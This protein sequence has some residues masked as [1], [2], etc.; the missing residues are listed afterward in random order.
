[1]EQIPT[2]KPSDPQPV[3]PNSEQR[4][5]GFWWNSLSDGVKAA[6]IAGV[7]GLC[8]ACI[9][10]AGALGAPIV[11]AWLSRPTATFTPPST[12]AP[13][14]TRPPT[15]TSVPPTPTKAIAP[16]PTST[17]YAAVE[18]FTILK[19]GIVIDLVR[20]DETTNVGVGWSVTVRAEIFASANL[21]DLKFTWWT[22]QTGDQI[23]VWG[24]GILEMPYAAPTV[25][26]HDCIRVKIEKG[27]E[28]LNN[29][30][31][32]VNIQ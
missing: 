7:F 22:C 27:G 21:V 28:V 18:V 19:D 25:T 26:G 2:Q 1:M 3:P 4:E 10:F 16:T 14:L 11:A 13:P 8:A 17:P 23:V 24:N 15:Y 20:P 5:I 6:Y 12:I 30:V 31:F 29:R 32:Y 9:G